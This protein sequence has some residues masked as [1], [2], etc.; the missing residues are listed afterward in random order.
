MKLSRPGHDS[1]HHE[2]ADGIADVKTCIGLQDDSGLPNCGIFY[3]ILRQDCATQ[4][5]PE[6][7]PRLLPGMSAT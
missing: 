4:V 5:S 1:V 6:V 7:A 3:E 2:S